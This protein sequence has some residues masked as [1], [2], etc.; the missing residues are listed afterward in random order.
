MQAIELI[1]LLILAALLTWW[2]RRVINKRNTLKNLGHNSS[3]LSTDYFLGLNYLLNDEPDE[4][5]DTFI[6]ALQLNSQTMESHLALGTLLRRRGKVDK[7]IKTHQ[8]L[9]TMQSPQSDFAESVRL[10]LAS[11]Y[12]AAGLFDRAE[13]LLQ[14]VFQ[15]NK[16]SKW[17]ALKQ[18]QIIYQTEKEWDKAIDCAALLLKGPKSNK[19]ARL[20]AEAAHYCCELAESALAKG[21]SSAVKEQIKRAFNFDRHS[22]RA[23]LLGAKIAQAEKNYKLAIKELESVRQDNPAFTEQLIKPLG[24]C[25]HGLDDRVGYKQLLSACLSQ[26]PRMSVCLEMAEL[27]KTLEG[28]QASIEYLSN[29]LQNKPSLRGLGAV[30][31]LQSS[32]AEPELK[33]NLQLLTAA[34]EKHLHSKPAYHCNQC[35]FQAKRFYWLCPSCQSWD[36]IEAVQDVD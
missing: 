3:K 7:A 6:S 4:A 20:R 35:G 14:E 11:D 9:L 12:V 15:D 19:T 5:I 34:L 28:E 16:P 1:I 29:Y 31:K 36:G 30:L 17:A 23:R 22:I 2:L 10:E 27:I 8:S 32:Q 24:D 26:Q 18:L 25:Y 33:N 21:D 13:R